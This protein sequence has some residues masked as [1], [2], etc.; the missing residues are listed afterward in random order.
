MSMTFR[1]WWFD[2]FNAL[3]DLSGSA[4]LNQIYPVVHRLRSNRNAPLGQY[5]AWVRN[6]LQNNSRGRGHDVFVHLA[7]GKWG[8]KAMQKAP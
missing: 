1:E 4:F 2:V 6:A 3:A 7:R 8:I 5:E